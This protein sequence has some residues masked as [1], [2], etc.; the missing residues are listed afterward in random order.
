M[1]KIILITIIL[2]GISCLNG[3]ANNPPLKSA[4]CKQDLLYL[5]N[6]LQKNDA[7]IINTQ[8]VQAAAF[9]EKAAST[10]LNNTAQLIEQ[11]HCLKI[12]HSYVRHYRKGHLDV[13]KTKPANNYL[14]FLTNATIKTVLAPSVELLSKDTL[15]IDIP[16]FNHLLKAEFN[17]ILADNWQ[18]LSETPNWIIDLT[19]NGGGSDA[20]FG[21]LQSLIVT[22][23][24][25]MDGIELLVTTENIQAYK[26]MAAK[27]DV[28]HLLSAHTKFMQQQPTYGFALYKPAQLQPVEPLKAEFNKPK[29]VV[30]LTSERCASSCEQFVLNVKNSTNVV[31]VG[32]NTAGVI[33]ISN[34]VDHT[35][36]SS[37]FDVRY[38]ISRST[39][40]I[41]G[42]PIDGVGIEPDFKLE[43]S[44]GKKAKQ[45]N[46]TQVQEMIELGKL[47]L[48][49][50]K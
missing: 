36:P 14:S 8:N 16:S 26:N 32:Q 40:V 42:N 12:L 18:L 35:L 6:Y 24:I 10:Q 38:S 23:P 21:L 31:L 5:H 45:S 22:S 34:Q 33:D 7:G 37:L 25:H 11:N 4:I 50:Y 47:E 49:Q 17:D 39:R 30:L 15:L 28:E 29:L 41:S 3:C 27:Y 2:L 19:S 48:N 20:T 1:K 9:L 13:S 44:R 43:L 46:I